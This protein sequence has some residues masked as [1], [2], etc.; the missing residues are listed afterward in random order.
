[1]GDGPDASEQERDRADRLVRY[2]QILFGCCATGKPE[3]L[4]CIFYGRDGNNGKTTLL[5]TVAKALGNRE[6]ATQINIDSLMMDP[7]GAG[8]NNATNSDLSDLQGARF[9]FT[10]EVDSAQRLSLGRVKYLTGM[11]DLRTRRMRENW[12]TFPST[13]KIIMDCN[14]RPVVSNPSDA[15]WN[16]LVSV[17]FDVVIPDDEIDTDLPVKLEAELPGI[18]AWIIEGA[19]RYYLEGLRGRPAEVEMS[20]GEYRQTA[21]RLCE[22]IQDCCGL[23]EFAWVSSGQLVNAYQDWCRRNGEK[24]PLEGRDFTD[25]IKAKGCAPKTKEIQ[26]KPTRGWAGIELVRALQPGFE[27][28]ES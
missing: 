15:V 24:F 16:R 14:E 9:A 4:L 3:K 21:D 26:G 22:F 17:P 6:Y 18:L 12:I 28:G 23:N 7:R 19:R 27:G 1:M 11:S 13:H 2:L 5:T 20:T 25:Q 8:T 10:S